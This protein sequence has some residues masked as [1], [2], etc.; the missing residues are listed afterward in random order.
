M[1]EQP[2]KPVVPVLDLESEDSGSS[3]SRKKT[4]SERVKGAGKSIKKIVTPRSRSSSVNETEETKVKDTA[5]A[6]AASAPAVDTKETVATATDAS[7]GEKESYVEIAKK[8]AKKALGMEEK[9]AVEEEDKTPSRLATTGEET[10]VSKNNRGLVGGLAAVVVL[11]VGILLSK[12]SQ[13]KPEPV[14]EKKK[15]FMKQK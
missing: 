10:K 8:A 6:A 1:S 9:P 12:A 2:S 15:S 7:S 14:V 13:K 11:A 5:A 3:I 4:F